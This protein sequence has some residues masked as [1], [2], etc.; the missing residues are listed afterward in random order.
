MGLTA[1][2]D[3]SRDDRIL[4]WS[5]TGRAVVFALAATSIA[6][7]L[8]DFYG[9]LSMRA[10]ALLVFVPA[11]L[12]LTA[13]TVADGLR[14]DR[15]LFANVAI[16]AAAGVAAA[17]AYDLFRVPFVFADRWGLAAALPQLGLFKV[18]P[19]FGAM[20]LGDPAEQEGY[21]T[22]AHLLGWAY[23]FSNGAS[24]GIMYLAMLGDGAR[25]SWCWALPWA[26]GLELGMLFTPY[27]RQLGIELSTSFVIV[28]LTA[29]LVFG[30][31]LGLAVRWMCR[32]ARI[33]PR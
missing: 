15:R 3:M 9:L 29:H 19:M 25:R 33:S 28:T 18:F 14:H 6:C 31:V 27:P 20:L 12:T 5:P 21:S 13:L 24:F 2:P 22:A 26:A 4:G 7:L 32:L 11:S 17:A 10:F 23:H 16:G 30:V 8:A 1:P